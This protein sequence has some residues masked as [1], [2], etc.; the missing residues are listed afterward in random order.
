MSEIIFSSITT[1]AGVGS[2]NNTLIATYSV[3]IPA[4]T[5]NTS[6][7][8]LIQ[9][10]QLKNGTTTTLGSNNFRI[11]LNTSN[12]LTGATIIAGLANASTAI[13]IYGQGIRYFKILDNTIQGYPSA[14]GSQIDWNQS[15]TTSLSTTFNTNVDN[16]ILISAQMSANTTDIVYGAFLK[17]LGF[18]TI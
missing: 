7:A 13:T 17:I 2:S 14:V 8:L 18:K 1:S 3:L 11:Y 5:F 6:G 4:R 10:R 12:T 15:T 9:T 16:Y